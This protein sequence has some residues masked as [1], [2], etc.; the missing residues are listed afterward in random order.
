VQVS[1]TEIEDT[2]LAHPGRLIVD[3]AVAGVPGARLAD[4][5]VPRA[6]VVLSP[7]GKRRG[8]RYV[9]GTL[10]SWVRD[11]LSR[12]KWLRG[13]VQVVEEVRGM[14]RVACAVGL[15]RSADTSWTDSEAADG[16]SVTS[17]VAAGLRGGCAEGR[18]RAREVMTKE[19]CKR[20]CLHEAVRSFNSLGVYFVMPYHVSL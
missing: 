16:E 18:A 10:D 6:W 7:E 3:A 12:P 9:V 19:L 17:E 4:E 11:R 8:E 14:W 13:G 5:R 2:L 15:R 20:G 1:P